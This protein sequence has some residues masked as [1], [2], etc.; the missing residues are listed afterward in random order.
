MHPDGA[1]HAA[2]NSVARPPAAVMHR[3]QIC[4]FDRR[5]PIVGSSWFGQVQ[6]MVDEIRL[7]AGPCD[8]VAA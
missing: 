7:K 4:G 3:R 1:L 8:L 6:R 2:V 5:R